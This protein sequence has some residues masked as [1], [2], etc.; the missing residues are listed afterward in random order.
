MINIADPHKPFY[1]QAGSGETIPDPHAPSRV[2]TP[3]EPPTPG[4]LFEDPVVSKELAH[5]YSSVRRA[6]DGVGHVLQGAG[7]FGPGRQHAGDVPFRPRHAAA[8]RQD[9]ALPPQHAHAADRP[10]AGRH[11]GRAPWTTQ[12]MVS[13][14]DFLPT[15]LDVVGLEHPEGMDGRSFAPLLEGREAG[16]ARHGH[17]GVQRE[18]R[19]LA[20]S[21]AGRP[22]EA[23]ALHLQPLVERRAGDGHGDHRHADLSPHG[24]TGQDRRADRGPPRPVSASRGRGAVRHRERSRLPGEPDRLARPPAG[25][26]QAAQR[27]WKRGWSAPATTCWTFSATGTTR[28]CARRTCV[29]KEKEAD[30]RKAAEEAA[31]RRPARRRKKAGGADHAG[32]SQVGRRRRVA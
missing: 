14:V 27:L 12:H 7:G 26:G 28:P 10:L 13:A 22:D 15:L 3:D 11:Q 23:A 16:R 32:N 17:Q 18:R 30:A 2:F 6:D 29:E 19:R 1:A 25:A 8:V 20:R 9:A 21:D 24:G 5:Y 4:F 31:R